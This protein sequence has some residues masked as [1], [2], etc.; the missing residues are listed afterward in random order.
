M[1]QTVKRGSCSKNQ[2]TDRMSNQFLVGLN[3]LFWHDPFALDNK[4]RLQEYHH[5][6]LKSG[7]QQVGT[8]LYIANHYYNQNLHLETRKT[9]QGRGK[10]QKFIGDTL[11]KMVLLLIGASQI[12]K[13]FP[14]EEDKERKTFELFGKFL[15]FHSRAVSH[16][17]GK[18]WIKIVFQS[19]NWTLELELFLFYKNSHFDPWI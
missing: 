8:S 12:C 10:G 16:Y 1:W 15:S 18:N 14:E 5:R 13:P 11:C 6:H 17:K 4:T 19:L 2:Q 9:W 3:F 7:C